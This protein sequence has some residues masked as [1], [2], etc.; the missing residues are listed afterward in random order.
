[1]N[2]PALILDTLGLL[3]FFAGAWATLVLM[4]AL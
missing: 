2:I 3:A 1:M 4:W